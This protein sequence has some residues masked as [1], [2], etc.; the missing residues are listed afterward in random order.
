MALIIEIAL[1]IVR[2]H[3]AEILETLRVKGYGIATEQILNF[4]SI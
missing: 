3:R 4:N 2:E 1:G